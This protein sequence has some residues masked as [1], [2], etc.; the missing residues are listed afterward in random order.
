MR[1]AKV[2][3]QDDLAGILVET[4]DG[5]YEFTYDKEYLKSFPER[6]L[7]FTMPV[8]EKKYRSN[9]LFPF[10]EGLIPEGWLLEIASKNW[11]IN[12]NDRMGLLMACCRNC[13]GAV[14]VVPIEKER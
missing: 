9:R 6:F 8:S 3:Y 14:S 5:E 10:F 12:R 1:Q 2:Y 13:I 11:K 7:T 4:D